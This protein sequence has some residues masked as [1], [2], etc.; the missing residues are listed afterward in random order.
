MTTHLPARVETWFCQTCG[1][2]FDGPD[3]ELAASR[4]EQRDD[5]YSD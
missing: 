4:C 2:K 5:A 3:A 1:A